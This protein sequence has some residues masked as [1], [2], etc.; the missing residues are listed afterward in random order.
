MQ[1]Y[2]HGRATPEH[3]ID[4]TAETV[5]RLGDGTTKAVV[6]RTDNEP[7]DGN[8]DPLRP[9]VQIDRVER[10]SSKGFERALLQ[11]DIVLPAG[12]TDSNLVDY[13]GVGLAGDY[14]Q[15]EFSSKLVDSAGNLLDSKT[16][17]FL[18]SRAV[19]EVLRNYLLLGEDVP[20]AI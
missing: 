14:A 3:I 4:Q 7:R 12:V 13:I 18:P 20:D 9:F 19:I 11:R 8:R 6:I 1:A 2:R 15:C 17:R 16:Y 5:A 10:A